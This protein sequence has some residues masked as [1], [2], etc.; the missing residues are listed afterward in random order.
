MILIKIGHF[1]AGSI[2]D[3]LIMDNVV[4]INQY[5]RQMIEKKAYGVW[6]K[7]FGEV[8]DIDTRMKDLSDRVLGRLSQPGDHSTHLFYEMIMGIFEFGRAKHFLYL[9]NHQKMAIV[10]IHLFLADHCRFEMMRRLNWLESHGCL[11]LPLVKIVQEFNHT[12]RACLNNFPELVPSH[13]DYQEYMNL[14]PREKQVFIRKKLNDALD[15]FD[16]QKL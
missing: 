3:R 15:A 8:F 1:P 10:D 9:D 6:E 4:N 7:A 12:K 5:R 14:I 2:K 11:T 16:K 13:P